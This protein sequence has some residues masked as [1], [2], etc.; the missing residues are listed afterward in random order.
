MIYDGGKII[1]GLVIGVGLLLAPFFYNAGKAAKAP[2]PELAPK[3]KEAKVCVA[4]TEYMRTSHM[5]LLDK[6]RNEV[7]RDDIRYY[8]T[9]E[10]KVFYKGLQGT[11]LEC[12]SNKTKFCD[13][14][15][16]YLDVQPYCWDCHLV[17]KENK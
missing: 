15:H 5:H 2:E 16:N 10:G 7:V 11:C 13:E 9:A 12:H 1:T 8:K 17:P 14:C 3:A 6:W 4:S